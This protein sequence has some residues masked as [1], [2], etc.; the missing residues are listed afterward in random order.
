MSKEKEA[1]LVAIESGAATFAEIVNVSGCDSVDV[2]R[3]LVQLCHDRTIVKDK[4]DFRWNI[5]NKQ[6]NIAEGDP[7]FLWN[8]GE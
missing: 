3:A 4:S 2:M 8:K 7:D 1:V 5:R 6:V